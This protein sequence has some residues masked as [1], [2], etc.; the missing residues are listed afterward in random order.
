ML[1]MG[2]Q[3]TAFGWGGGGRDELYPVFLILDLLT[4]QSPVRKMP[5]QLVND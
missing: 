1:V 2:F 5:N 4:L 3:K